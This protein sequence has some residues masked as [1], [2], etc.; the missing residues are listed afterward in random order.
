MAERQPRG[1]RAE[2]VFDRDKNIVVTKGTNVADVIAT[3]GLMGGAVR[4]VY[5]GAAMAATA[6]ALQRNLDCLGSSGTTPRGSAS[7]TPRGS[8]RPGTSRSSASDAAARAQRTLSAR[9][10]PRSSGGASA[11]ASRPRPTTAHP[12]ARRRPDSARA[13]G[14]PLTEA[15]A[16]QGQAAAEEEDEEDA[17]LSE[18]A[19]EGGGGGRVGALDAEDSAAS[20]RG[21]VMEAVA[22]MREQDLEARLQAALADLEA[23][24]RKIL[25]AQAATQAAE[26]DAG[27]QRGVAE[28]AGAAAKRAEAA[29]ATSETARRNS[30]RKAKGLEGELA[31]LR[32]NLEE[33]RGQI[34]KLVA[35]AVESQ[36]HWERERA[37]HMETAKRL[38]SERKGDEKAAL[39][40]ADR[41]RLEMQQQVDALKRE[42]AARDAASASLR[43]DLEAARGATAAGAEVRQRLEGQVRDL[44]VALEKAMEDASRRDSQTS[45]A[46]LAWELTSKVGD[47]TEKEKLAAERKRA[48]EL[49]NALRKAN[50]QYAETRERHASA[51]A[52][53]EERLAACEGKQAEVL[54]GLAASMGVVADRTAALLAGRKGGVASEASKRRAAKGGNKSAAMTVLEEMNDQLA[55]ENTELLQEVA[56]LRDGAGPRAERSVTSKANMAPLVALAAREVVVAQK[57]EILEDDTNAEDEKATARVDNIIAATEENIQLRLELQGLRQEVAALQ[58]ARHT[59]DAQSGSAT[60]AAAESRRQ[61][62]AALD[63]A[64]LERIGA[65]TELHRLKS[66]WVPPETLQAETA[67][68]EAAKRELKAA[69]EDALR[70]ANALSAAKSERAHRSEAVQRDAESVSRLQV[71]VEGLREDVRK[72]DS[73][74]ARLRM[75]LEAANNCLDGGSCAGD[76]GSVSGR[77]GSARP[78]AGTDYPRLKQ[79]LA[80][81]EAAVARLGAEAAAAAAELDKAQAGLGKA[82][83]QLA[84]RTQEKDAAIKA[85]EDELRFAKDT[86]GRQLEA[87]ASS[88]ATAKAAA[89]EAQAAA[90]ALR[91]EL[92]ATRT[93]AERVRIEHEY[94]R[95]RAAAEKAGPPR[96]KQLGLCRAFA[97]DVKPP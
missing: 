44:K 88:A 25:H 79:Q 37:K 1:S 60:D 8:S 36:K 68:L 93:E 9:A 27:R 5:D 56:R 50:R 14:Q 33:S 46:M 16:V 35:E 49:A 80:D 6:A 73:Q 81:K 92:A 75:Q 95:G 72:R 85:L 2:P 86:L 55:A 89:V 20:A 74:M 82:K 51:L 26:E 18:I 31:R 12:A 38:R 43:Q 62:E 84:Q 17:M 70:K 30:D 28:A 87:E 53:L 32:G 47:E 67:K 13:P 58:A 21:Y 66:S 94:L 96:R 83:R 59:A 41:L 10:D 71:E 40:D 45:A 76:G 4:R 48:G 69:K 19:R 15:W 61:L 63:A 24:Q 11:R 90:G 91:A 34:D 77:P 57:R 65:E 64:R 29:A 42:L 97:I 78:G 7:G 23:S 39:A 22:A 54:D 52:G 3:S